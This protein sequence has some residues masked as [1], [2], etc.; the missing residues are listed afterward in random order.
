MPR[1]AP[2]AGLAVAIIGPGAVGAALAQG[3][4]AAG[5]SVRL[6]SRTPGRAAEVRRRL[7][8]GRARPRL[9]A[10][11]DLARA[12]RAAHVVLL[13]VGDEALEDAG[14]RAARALEPGAH[15]VALH[16]HGALG[17][18]A[19]SALQRAGSPVGVLHPLAPLP[20]R[21]A[22]S[23]AGAFFAVAGDPRAAALARRIARGLGGRALAL[24]DGPAQRLAYHAAASLAAGGLVALFDAALLP[25]AGAARDPRAARAALLDLLARTLENLRQGSAA[26]AL[27][28]AAARGSEALVAEHLA[29]LARHGGGRDGPAELYRVLARRMVALARQR[30]SLAPGAARRV[31]ARLDRA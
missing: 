25:L 24:R 18:E 23:L 17:P 22:P 5:A 28:G 27:T 19:L 6:W 14:E 29:A 9:A 30:G 31:L 12:L 8:G 4:L 21:G 16:T 11:A 2:L 10:C 15:P 20:L 1:T 13:A 7:A 3:L 26:G